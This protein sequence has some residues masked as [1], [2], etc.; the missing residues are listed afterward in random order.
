[1]NPTSDPAASA[2]W[3]DPRAI[4]LLLAAT[5][6]VMAAATISP[7]LP[8]LQ[9]QFP[10]TGMNAFLI[11]LLVPAPALAVVLAAPVCGRIADRKGRRRMLLTGVTLYA[12]AGSV[13]LF[14]TDLPLLLAS[15]LV[16]GV[17]LAMI[18]T[19][20]SALLGDYFTGDR[21]RTL[22]GAQVSA[23][24]FGGLLFITLAGFLAE[25]APRLPFAIYVLAIL[26]LPLLWRAIDEPRPHAAKAN[27]IPAMPQI[28]RWRRTVR[29]LALGQIATTMVFFT[30]PTQLPFFLEYRG[31]ESPAVTG[32]TLAAMMLAGGI[33]ALC[34][35][36][37]RAGCGDGGTWAIA[38]FLMAAGF[39]VLIGVAGMSG[40]MIGA[41]AIG[42]GYSLAIPGFVA[43]SLSVTPE[44]S[45]G[46]TGAYLTT[47]AFLG[48]FLSPLVS[49][50]A[51]NRWG[52]QASCLGLAVM[53]IIVA[54]IAL[55]AQHC[56]A[57][58]LLRHP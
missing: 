26:L 58:R 15:R 37:I 25:L 35:P 12:V 11:R 33:A 49:I 45:R 54:M 13:G 1:M 18:M 40:A 20:Q 50:P 14:P 55:C 43:R 53:L 34:Y 17:A 56:V 4:G 22:S 29:L 5:L 2:I 7:A 39:A 57:R 16:L 9:Q 31:L 46:W 19:A 8:G 41:A 42:G 3:H 38:F 28:A 51:I 23:R 10:A 44:N 21:L 32:A 47:A 27:A 48:Q 30:M 6:T 36:R 52:W 24:N